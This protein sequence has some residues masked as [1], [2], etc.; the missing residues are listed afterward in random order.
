MIGVSY[1]V[2]EMIH[3]ARTVQGLAKGVNALGGVACKMKE[4]KVISPQTA[5]MQM[6][7]S[8]IL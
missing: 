2:D 4:S 1:A 3:W 7:C 6:M 8:I 5:M